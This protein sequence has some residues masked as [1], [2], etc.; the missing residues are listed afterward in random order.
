MPKM[1]NL[2][3]YPESNSTSGMKMLLEKSFTR[4]DFWDES[5]N[6]YLNFIWLKQRDW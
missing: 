6:E 3:D 1:Q 2:Q 4:V 5:S